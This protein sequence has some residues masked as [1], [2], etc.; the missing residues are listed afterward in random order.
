M[1]DAV[2]V[3]L[4]VVPDAARP[5]GGR[6]AAG[7]ERVMAMGTTV[8]AAEAALRKP[9]FLLNGLAVVV[10]GQDTGDGGQRSRQPCRPLGDGGQVA[11]GAGLVQRRPAQ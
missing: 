11:V 10:G 6:R 5:S 3:P 2:T 9:Q 4:A 8:A 7:P 1:A